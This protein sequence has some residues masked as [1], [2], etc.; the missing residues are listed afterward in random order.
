[1]IRIDRD[2]GQQQPVAVRKVDGTYHL[3]FGYRRYAAVSLLNAEG[4]NTPL[5]AVEVTAD[6]Q[7]ALLLNILENDE[8]KDTTPVD[9]AHNV[10]RLFKEHGMTKAAIAEHYG[11]SPS[12]VTQTITLVK[13]PV[14]FQLL[15][16]R[17]QLSATAGYNTSKLKAAIKK[18]VLAKVL[19]YFTIGVDQENAPADIGCNLAEVDETGAPVQLLQGEYNRIIRQVQAKHEEV[20]VEGDGTEAPT[21]KVQ[22]GRKDVSTLGETI[23]ETYGWSPTVQKFGKTLQRWISGELKDDKR[24][25]MALKAIVNMDAETEEAA[26]EANNQ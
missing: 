13:L 19:N 22:R 14:W 20:H 1:M 23:V 18:D 12:W 3:V 5:E 8:R 24:L 10:Q 6:E 25:L 11:K 4:I 9:D 16:A 21:T 2:N 7:Q 17:G 15:I 26:F